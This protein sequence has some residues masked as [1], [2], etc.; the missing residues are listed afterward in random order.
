MIYYNSRQGCNGTESVVL[1]FVLGLLKR[2]WLTTKEACTLLG[3]SRAGLNKAI[4]QLPIT[5]CKIGRTRLYSREQTER[6][7]EK[8]SKQYDS[9]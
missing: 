1:N 6:L 3:Y 7:L 4:R 2:D 9:E 8:W 5:S